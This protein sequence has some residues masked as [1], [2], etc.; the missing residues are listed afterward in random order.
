ME[1]CS[2]VTNPVVDALVSDQLP[3]QDALGEKVP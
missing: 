1:T 3:V 2:K